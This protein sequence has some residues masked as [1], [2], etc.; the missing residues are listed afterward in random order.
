MEQNES[1]QEIDL[2]ELW[3]IFTK[4]IKFI[5][6]IVLLS[7]IIAA[8]ISYFVLDKKYE[9]YSTILL[10]KS[11]RVNQEIQQITTQDVQLNQQLVATYGEIIKSRN[12]TEKVTKNLKLNITPTKL[13][14]MITIA[15]VND[16]E[17]IKISVVH[18]DP[19][20]P[21]KIANETAVV[22]ME[23]VAELM[24]IDNVNI[25]DVAEA[26]DTPISPNPRLNIAISFI[27]GLMLGTFIVFIKEFLNTKI[28]NPK[29]VEA[30]S[31][32]PIL[33]VIP[34]SKMLL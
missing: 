6:I 10:G 4:N 34:Q 2:K 22:F 14:S 13:R 29:E 30:L 12:V 16:T 21:A 25:V 5:A 18:T 3:Y 7:M 1:T 9:S 20:L 32:Y 23:Y 24:K 28:K 8:S 17:M 11:D 33:A 31:K 19:I 26:Y 27:L 15:T